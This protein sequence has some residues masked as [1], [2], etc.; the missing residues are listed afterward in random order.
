LKIELLITTILMFYA[1]FLSVC[2]R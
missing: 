2:I 1:S